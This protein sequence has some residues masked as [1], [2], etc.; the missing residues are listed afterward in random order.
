[1]QPSTGLV[2]D[3]YFPVHLVV[4]ELGPGAGDPLARIEMAVLRLKWRR[5]R[6]APH[7]ASRCWTMTRRRDLRRAERAR[8]RRQKTKSRSSGN[9]LL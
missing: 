3:A 7:N 8:A 5:T 6:S 9:A 1:M 2:R 4:D